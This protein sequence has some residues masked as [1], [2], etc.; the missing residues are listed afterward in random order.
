MPIARFEL[1]D[2]QQFNFELVEN[3]LNYINISN[4]YST[5]YAGY[6]R[7]TILICLL[8]QFIDS[9]FSNDLFTKQVNN[10]INQGGLPQI[11]INTASFRSKI[12]S[13]EIEPKINVLESNESLKLVSSHFTLT[14]G[15][16][17]SL[18]FQ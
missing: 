18:A 10:S 2:K 4:T 15:I 6:Y 13:P 5:F 1:S 3:T 12:Q 14:N 17:F 16:I 8:G 7:V 9:T 11:A